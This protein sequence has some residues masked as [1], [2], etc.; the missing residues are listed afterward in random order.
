MTRGPLCGH[1]APQNQARILVLFFFWSTAITTYLYQATCTE[2]PQPKLEVTLMGY[3]KGMQTIRKMG[4]YI[5]NKQL[6]LQARAF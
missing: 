1:R 5:R 4:F 6:V 2:F 3:L